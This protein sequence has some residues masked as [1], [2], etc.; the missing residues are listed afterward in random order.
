[1]LLDKKEWKRNLPSRTW[2]Y[3][4]TSFLSANKLN[5]LTVAYFV[6]DLCMMKLSFQETNAPVKNDS[7]TVLLR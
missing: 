7:V 1:M 4:N 6:P 3:K 5:M 2:V